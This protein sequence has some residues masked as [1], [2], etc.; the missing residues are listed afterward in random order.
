MKRRK[1]DFSDYNNA[2]VKATELVRLSANHLDS[3][4]GVVRT[5]REQIEDLI[6]REMNASYPRVRSRFRNQR[7]RLCAQLYGFINGYR[8]ATGVDLSH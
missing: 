1:D 7:L 2:Y 6:E 5:L 3:A 4:N 8:D